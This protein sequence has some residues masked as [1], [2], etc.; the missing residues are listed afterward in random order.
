M[1]SQN[2]FSNLRFPSSYGFS[3]LDLFN[4]S[5]SKSDENLII[6]NALYEIIN[7]KDLQIDYT[8]SKM[9]IYKISR[10]SLELFYTILKPKISLIDIISLLMDKINNLNDV[11]DIIVLYQC[12]YH[13][14]SRNTLFSAYLKLLV[15]IELFYCT[16]NITMANDFYFDRLRFLIF[17]C[18]PKTKKI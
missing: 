1:N 13:F 18:I 6:Q 9:S 8:Y 10:I 2:Y 5:K 17:I 14:L 12:L 7:K 11:L 16:K 4:F 3:K 15:Y